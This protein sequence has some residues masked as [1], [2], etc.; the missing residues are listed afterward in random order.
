[1]HAKFISLSAAARTYSLSWDTL[2]RQITA[3]RLPA[4]RITPH[5]RILV[6]PEDVEQLLVALRPEPPQSKEEL[7]QMLNETFLR[8]IGGEEGLKK[9]RLAARLQAKGAGQTVH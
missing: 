1:M 9:A 5:G 4:F 6:K 2:R 8:S 7:R 3:G